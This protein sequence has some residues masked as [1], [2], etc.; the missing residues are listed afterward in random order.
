[1]SYVMHPPPKIGQHAPI[2]M[3]NNGMVASAQPLAAL[4]GLQ[5]LI[6]GGNAFDA[7]I[8]AALVEDVTLPAMT[9]LGGD[10]FALIYHHQDKKVYAINGSGCAPS[11]ASIDWYEQAGYKQL[12]QE[13]ILSCSV[14]GEI[15]ALMTIHE[16]FG[17]VELERLMQ[18]AIEYAENGFPVNERLHWRIQRVIEKLKRYPQTEAVFLSNGEAPKVGSR[19][20][21]KDLA[22]TLKTLMKNGLADFYQGEIAEQIVTQM[23]R[24]GGLITENDLAAHQ[25]EI[26]E[27]ISTD[28]RGYTI[29]ETTP[30]SQGLIVLEALNILEGFNIAEMGF[31][32]PEWIHHMVEA[33]KLA[34][35]DRI[36]YCGDPRF[37][38]FDMETLLSKEHAS[39]QRNWI[40]GDRTLE[41]YNGMVEQIDGDT[42]YLAVADKYGNCVS[43]IHSLS[44]VEFGSGL[45]LGDTGIV[46]NS[47]LGRGF[48]F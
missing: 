46:L 22:K 38:S 12:P 4:A 19:L 16:K 6:E 48:S 8:A 17:S 24:A 45:I 33:K 27:P 43:L 39:Q 28:Y 11:Q 36:K 2:A 30:P 15:H 3:G 5:V 26:G 25:T 35:S 14:P 41:H 10:L 23:S 37:V 47:R 29:Y 18:P 31:Q 34:Y 40:R 9:T 13:G 21:Q 1:M 20:Y 44:G 7:A 32:S 42:T